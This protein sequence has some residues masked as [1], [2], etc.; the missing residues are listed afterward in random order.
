MKHCV[1]LVVIIGSILCG[2][3]LAAADDEDR[4]TE[5]EFLALLQAGHP[6]VVALTERLAL[7]EGERRG[8]TWNN[9][10][11]GFDREA[12]RGAAKQ[13]IWWL[14]WQPPLDGRQG[15]RKRAAEAGVRAAESEFVWTKLRLRL[16]LR[17][18][19]AD[20]VQTTERRELL[21]KHLE[22]ISR[23]ADRARAR[24]DIGEESGL[25]A[26]RLTLAAVEVRVE[27][28]QADADLARTEA[29]VREL[30]P[31]LEPG[32]QPVWPPLPPVPAEV[33]W[34]NRPDL[35]ARRFEM[36]QAKL[37]KRLSGRFLEFP[38]LM[39]GWTRFD[40]A[41]GSVDG[42][43]FALSWNLPLFDR[44]QG[45]RVQ[46]ARNVVIV[47]AQL[48]LANAQAKAQLEAA[49]G[50]YARLRTATTEVTT[51]TADADALV[52]S[53][54]AA[55]RVGESTLTDLLETLRSALSSQMAALN[56]HHS[57]LQAHRNLE[58][59]AGLCPS[60]GGT[61]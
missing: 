1:R 20:W 35:A 12:P 3:I 61:K 47:E 37:K 24:A 31:D 6:A 26:R 43:V 46:E 17:G 23:L 15:L 9:P 52:A 10:E 42:P 51:A 25:V 4:L 29:K 45:E 40:G 55:F 54:T 34:S 44:N 32:V 39:A 41:P 28:A 48:E 5:E 13:S 21:A 58:A 27:L 59:S 11:I 2:S 57:A 14:R 36:E 49:Y 53:A 30:H 8:V 19:Y 7:A 16:V 38:E 50:V 33:G 56:L 18:V 60:S 22:V